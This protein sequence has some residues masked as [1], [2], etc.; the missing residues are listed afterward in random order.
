MTKTTSAN[1]GTCG[2]HYVAGQLSGYNLC[3]GLPRGGAARSDIF[4]ARES[5]GPGFR[6]QVK[7]GTQST[8]NDKELGPIYLWKMSPKAIDDYDDYFWYAYVWLNGWPD[9]PTLP[10]V[11]FVPSKVVSDC[12]RKCR[13]D[14]ETWLYFWM[15]AQDAVQYKG[16]DGLEFLMGDSRAEPI[17]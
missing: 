10:E 6:I 16:R 1:I 3:V 5:G 15:H 7:T 4:V 14:G 13:D 11:F 17:D 9:A 8:K 2:E 12:I